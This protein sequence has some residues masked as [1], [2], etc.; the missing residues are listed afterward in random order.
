MA[1]RASRGIP[2]AAPLS[3]GTVR[4]SE[5]QVGDVID[6]LRTGVGQVIDRFEPYTGSLQGVLGAGV[7]VARSADGWGMTVG[8]E[9]A[10]RILPRVAGAVADA[11]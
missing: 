6:Y 7:R 5:L 11:S 10:I 8:P 3:D 1:R 2:Q 9:A 4:G